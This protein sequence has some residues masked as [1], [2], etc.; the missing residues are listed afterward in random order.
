MHAF[1]VQCWLLLLYGAY[2]RCALCCLLLLLVVVVVVVV[3]FIVYQPQFSTK[4]KPGCLFFGLEVAVV[5]SRSLSSI[6]GG[7]GVHSVGVRA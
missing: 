4:D 2:R 1:H 7:G 3:V 6:T 5:V